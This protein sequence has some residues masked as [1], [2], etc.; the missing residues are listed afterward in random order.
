MAS[1]GKLRQLERL[2]VNAATRSGLNYLNNLSNLQYLKVDAWHG[3]VTTASTDEL[4]LDLSGLTRMREF[5]LSGCRCTSD[6][7]AF[8]RIC[9][10]LRLS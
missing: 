3:A 2:D 8:L 4:L 7:L 9:P 10:R 1:I 6:D 5:Y